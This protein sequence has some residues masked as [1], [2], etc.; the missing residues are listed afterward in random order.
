MQVSVMS[1]SIVSDKG[2]LIFVAAD[3]VISRQ[4][5]IL[6]LNRIDY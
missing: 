1:E 5:Y 4:R 2:V 6:L 3:D